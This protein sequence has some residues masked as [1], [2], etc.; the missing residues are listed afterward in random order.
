MMLTP[1]QQETVPKEL[2]I[3]PLNVQKLQELE[4]ESAPF[5]EEVSTLYSQAD[6]ACV[7]SGTP[8]YN[9]LMKYKGLGKGMGVG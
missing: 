9:I 1:S 7:A 2:G 6:L 5:N 8:G 3:A 4:F